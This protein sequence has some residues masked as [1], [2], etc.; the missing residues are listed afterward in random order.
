MEARLRLGSALLAVRPHYRHGA[1][2]DALK[3]CEINIRTAQRAMKVA[4]GVLAEH[5]TVDAAIEYCN[6]NDISLHQA[7]L[8]AGVRSDSRQ[9][10]DQKRTTVRIRKMI[11]CDERICL[12]WGRWS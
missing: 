8:A 7:E 6:R 5:G 10:V 9:P 3:A 11:G 1:W 2:T 12:W 4:Q